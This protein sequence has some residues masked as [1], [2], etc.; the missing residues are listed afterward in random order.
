MKKTLACIALASLST[1]AAADGWK[2]APGLT[3][4]G[5]K[6]QPTVAA[7]VG[8]VKPQG[9]GSSVT[10][11]GVEVNVNCGLI[12]TPDNR[13]RTHLSLNRINEDRFDATSVELSPRYT[14]PLAAGFS[15]GVGPSLGLVRVDPSANGVSKETLF[16]YGVAA[17]VNYRA[18]VLYTGLDLGMKRASEKNGIDFDNRSATFKVGVNF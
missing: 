3:E 13:I 14:L 9:D 17:G 7:T 16:T 6:L 10:A 5:F 15:V 8:S 18:G 12:Q 4:P 11:Y 2:F 1:L